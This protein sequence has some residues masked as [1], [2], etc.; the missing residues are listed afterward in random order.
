[1]K[2]IPPAPS[3][4]VRTITLVFLFQQVYHSGSSPT[5]KTSFKPRSSSLFTIL[6]DVFFLF[7]FFLVSNYPFT[8]TLIGFGSQWSYFVSQGSPLPANWTTAAS[9]ASSWA[10]GFAPIGSSSANI[11]LYNTAA[12]Y[13]PSAATMYLVKNFTVDPQTLGN[14]HQL[15]GELSWFLWCLWD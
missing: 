8:R 2:V 1:M 9:P 11:S 12:P 5:C 14:V 10:T 3:Q 4:K 7:F 6:L 15:V 13:S